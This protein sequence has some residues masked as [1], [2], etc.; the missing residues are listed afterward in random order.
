MAVVGKHLHFVG[1]APNKIIRGSMP[2][3]LQGEGDMP[4]FPP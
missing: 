2:V 1:I 3:I 4:S